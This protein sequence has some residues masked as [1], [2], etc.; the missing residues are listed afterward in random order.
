MPRLRTLALLA[1][2]ALAACDSPPAEKAAQAST[3]QGGGPVL[4]WIQDDYPAALAQAR[5]RNVP[6]FVESWAPW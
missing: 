6:L 4:P 1:P 3:A 2:L 5:Q